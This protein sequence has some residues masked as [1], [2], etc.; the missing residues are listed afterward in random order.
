MPNYTRVEISDR[1]EITVGLKFQ[2]VSACK[3]E[4]S[5]DHK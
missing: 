2:L 3:H 1:V 4:E 5:F